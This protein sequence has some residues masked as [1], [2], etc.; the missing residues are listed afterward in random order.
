MLPYDHTN[1]KAILFH[2]NEDEKEIYKPLNHD[3][4]LRW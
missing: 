2:L 3:K 1:L 4:R